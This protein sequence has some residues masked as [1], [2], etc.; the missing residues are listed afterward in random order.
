[1]TRPAQLAAAVALL[2][3]PVLCAD[4]PSP[5]PAD[6]LPETVPHDAVPLGLGPRPAAPDNP[7]TAARVALGRRLFFDPILSADS[8]VACATCH[9]PEHGFSSPE[10]RPRGVG[11]RTADRRPPTL[12]NRAYGKAFFW[13][14]R[15]ATLEEQALKPIENPAEMGSTVAAA[16][17]R[18][19][20]DAGYKDRFAAAFDDGVTA[21]NLARALAGFERVL[22]RGD[23]PVD[24]FR[25]RGQRGA[26]TEAELHGFWLYESK[27]QCWRCHGGPNFT[28]EGYHNTGV[29][30]G[31]AD[32]GRQAVTKAEADRGKF[33][34]PTLRGVRLRPPYMHDGSVKT[35]EDVVDFY[36]RGG[37]ANPN[38]DPAVRT[39]DLTPDERRDLVAFLK[40][41]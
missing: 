18:L 38:L 9:Q 4:K 11:G 3:A 36:T 35:L 41:L 15:A 31:G 7:L 10:P 37:V 6:T 30:W 5:P 25:Q 39:L 27:G 12:L 24:K 40:A 33:K 14:G 20:A 13:D 22:L 16:V 28:D 19:K 29:G 34:T 23:S 26:M 2:A 8:T 17:A 21:V 32:V 1:M